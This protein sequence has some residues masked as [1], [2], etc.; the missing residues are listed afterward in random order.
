M[1][2]IRSLYSLKAIGC[3]FVVM[4]HVPFVGRGPA[5]PIINA[6]VPLFLMI[7]G[8]LLWEPGEDPIMLS[9]KL[10]YAFRKMVRVIV[11]VNAVYL[12]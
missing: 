7:S 3:L 9:R 4:I 6:A 1:K 5:S 8:Y 11:I 10:A 12:L 2:P